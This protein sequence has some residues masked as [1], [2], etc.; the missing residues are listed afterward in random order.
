[1]LFLLRVLANSSGRRL[2]STLRLQNEPLD[3]TTFECN[4]R[5]LKRGAT[6]RPQQEEQLA[7]NC[8]WMRILHR[9]KLGTRAANR[10][11][12]KKVH[13]K[14]LD[15]GWRNGPRPSGRQALSRSVAGEAWAKRSIG[16]SVET[17]AREDHH[18]Q[19]ETARFAANSKSN[20][21]HNLRTINCFAMS[22]S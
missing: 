1:M 7:Q 3:H 15:G 6:R 9:G 22:M 11:T 19:R 5:T 10:R 2:A 8:C 13:N 16:F 20:H 14:L 4:L 12:F 17:R 18:S 21:T